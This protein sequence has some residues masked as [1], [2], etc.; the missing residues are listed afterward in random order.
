MQQCS[1]L[2]GCRSQSRLITRASTRFAAC[3][4]H[5]PPQGCTDMPC[6]LPS[7]TQVHGVTL[8]NKPNRP[9]GQ[10]RQH[11][12]PILKSA[13][14]PPAPRRQHTHACTR[15]LLLTG[16]LPST[17]EC[18]HTIAAGHREGA[19]GRQQHATRGASQQ[20]F[21]ALFSALPYAAAAAAA[22]CCCYCRSTFFPLGSYA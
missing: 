11:P 5:L 15:P 12:Q 6:H 7:T 22:C 3:T 21:L 17:V 2:L 20:L 13:R 16:S 1:P 8:N 18:T 19:A 4:L 9:A 14:P 10:R